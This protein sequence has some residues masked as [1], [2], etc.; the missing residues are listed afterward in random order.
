MTE[1]IRQLPA[2]G[3]AFIDELLE[4]QDLG[5]IDMFDDSVANEPRVVLTELGAERLA[6]AVVE[7]LT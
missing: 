2:P 6:R 1:A 5:L 4:L 7:D 3:P